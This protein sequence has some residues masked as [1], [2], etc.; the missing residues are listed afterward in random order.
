[1]KKLLKKRFLGIPMAVIAVILV[2][3]I[4]LA[5]WGITQ[6][7]STG[8]ITVTAPPPE[9]VFSYTVEPTELAFGVHEVVGGA[10]VEFDVLVTV[11]NTGNQVI[12]CCTVTSAAVP[13][14][15]EMVY[16]DLEN[17]I[18][19]GNSGIITFRLKSES[20]PVGTFQLSGMTFTLT[21]HEIGY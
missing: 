3:T 16:E 8:K 21:P 20:A 14:G 13:A 7:T 10:W 5:A 9:P 19:P 12:G 18:T 1:L 6:L 2:A 15:F 17:D 11:H 4:V